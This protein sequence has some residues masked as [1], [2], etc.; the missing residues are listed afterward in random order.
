VQF[1]VSNIPLNF[2]E[3]FTKKVVTNFDAQFSTERVFEI[4][5]ANWFLGLIKFSNNCK[6]LYTTINMKKKKSYY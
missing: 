1:R 2:I 6:I 3:I 5:K 4:L